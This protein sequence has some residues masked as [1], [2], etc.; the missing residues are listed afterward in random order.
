MRLLAYIY[1]MSQKKC[2]SNILFFNK[3]QRAK[4]KKEMS[5]VLIIRNARLNPNFGNGNV[6]TTFHS[7]L[8]AK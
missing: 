5:V 2:L 6:S 8:I 3:I 1:R 7:L 4:G